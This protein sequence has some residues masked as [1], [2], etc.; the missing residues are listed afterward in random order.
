M[1]PNPD[2]SG[3][4][5]QGSAYLNLNVHFAVLCRNTIIPNNPP[6]Q[7]PS[8]PSSASVNSE[9]RCPERP[10]RHL[11][12]PNVRN[13]TALN[14]ANQMAANESETFKRGC[15]NIPLTDWRA[16]SPM[17]DGCL[18]GNRTQTAGVRDRRTADYATRQW[19]PGKVLPPRLLGVGQT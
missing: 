12:N 8:A 9:T 15:F 3:E 10:A 1:P 11:S 13:V 2:F 16:N 4:R 17:L 14:A 5:N 6:I 19:S 7:P 18:A